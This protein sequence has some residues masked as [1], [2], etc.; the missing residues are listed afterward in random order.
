MA[1]QGLDIIMPQLAS[2]QEMR[3]RLFDFRIMGMRIPRVP[4]GRRPSHDLD[5]EIHKLLTFIQMS[6]LHSYSNA[7]CISIRPSVTP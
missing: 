3:T 5:I 7:A 2:T 1:G 4:S 6:S